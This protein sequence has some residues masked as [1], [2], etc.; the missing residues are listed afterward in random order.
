MWY[1]IPTLHIWFELV[2]PHQLLPMINNGLLVT[3]AS[4]WEDCNHE[5]L[6]SII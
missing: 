2:P 4:K 3:N 5:S 6:L 1:P